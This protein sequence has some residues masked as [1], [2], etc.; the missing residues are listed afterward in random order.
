MLVK[1]RNFNRRAKVMSSNNYSIGVAEYSA[2]PFNREEIEYAAEVI[3]E[4]DDA[5]GLITVAINFIL[6]TLPNRPWEI[7]KAEAIDY[8]R[9]N[10]LEFTDYKIKD[11]TLK[12]KY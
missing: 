5:F 9:S 4:L 8:I 1:S 7:I 3:L 10:F 2:A 11:L 6:S 12:R